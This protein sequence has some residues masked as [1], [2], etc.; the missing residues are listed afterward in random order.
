MFH[1]FKIHAVEQVLIPDH[2]CSILNKEITPQVER[3]QEKV[4]IINW[5]LNP[6][7]HIQTPSL[8]CIDLLLT[9]FFHSVPLFGSMELYNLQRSH[10]IQSIIRLAEI[11]YM[12]RYSYKTILRRYTLK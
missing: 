11:K 4:Y 1:W 12:D 7:M 3:S 2:A 8:R 9:A 5:H 10:E 6:I